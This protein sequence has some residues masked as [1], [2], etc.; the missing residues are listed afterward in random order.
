MNKPTIDECDKPIGCHYKS[1]GVNCQGACDSRLRFLYFGV[2]GAD[3]CHDSNALDTAVRLKEA[4]D[5]LCLGG[6]LPL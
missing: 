6:Q 5:S 4:I 3:N 2:V 1:Y